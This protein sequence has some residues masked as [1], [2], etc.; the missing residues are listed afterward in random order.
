MTTKKPSKSIKKMKQGGARAGAGRP[1]T[2]R[3]EEGTFTARA[4]D[5]QILH[6]IKALTGE[7]LRD[8]FARLVREELRRVEGK[9]NKQKHTTS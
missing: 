7:T 3:I 8:I 2:G 6:Q 4:E 9:C 1:K 5:I